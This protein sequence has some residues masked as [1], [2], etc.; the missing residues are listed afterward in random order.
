MK[1]GVG[2]RVRLALAG[3]EGL[4]TVV[5]IERDDAGVSYIVRVDDKSFTS[6]CAPRHPGCGTFRPEW[7]QPDSRDP[8]T[9]IRFLLGETG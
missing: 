1:Y 2:D 3:A 9:V 5:A 4:G 6:D 8:D 7:L